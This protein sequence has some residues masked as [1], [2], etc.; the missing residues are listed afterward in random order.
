MGTGCE[1]LEGVELSFGYGDG[2]ES[3]T[4]LNLVVLVFA[5]C[6]FSEK[7]V[8]APAFLL[9]EPGLGVAGCASRPKE[10]PSAATQTVLVAQSYDISFGQPLHHSRPTEAASVKECENEQFHIAMQSHVGRVKKSSDAAKGETSLLGQ[11]PFPWSKC[12]QCLKLSTS[13]ESSTVTGFL[14]VTVSRHTSIVR[15]ETERSTPNWTTASQEEANVNT[16][17]HKLLRATRN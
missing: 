17:N 7:K 2:K 16:T 10:Y 4:D 8:S 6:M 12:Y 11:Y 13:A 14:G 1:L 5:G 15:S 3:C 9:F